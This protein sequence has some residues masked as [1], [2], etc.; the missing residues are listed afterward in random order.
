VLV[1]F[2][3][4]VLKD[5]G[6]RPTAFSDPPTQCGDPSPLVPTITP[7]VTGGD[8]PLRLTT[9][10]AMAHRH[11]SSCSSFYVLEAAFT[12]VLV[13]P[14]HM[15][16]VPG[17]KTDVQDCVW[18]AQLLEHGLLRGS[19]VP[20]APIRELRDLSRYRKVLIQD[21]TRE[22][23]RLHKLLEDA[24]IK[25]ASVATDVLGVS[26]R[27]M[28]EALVH[29]TTAPAVLA[30]LARGTL[31]KKLPALRQALAGRFRPHHAFL[32]S[33]LLAHL[34]YLDETIATLSQ[35][36]EEVIA[37]FAD[38]VARLDTIHGVAQRTAEVLI[39][40]LGVDMGQFPTDR[41]AVNESVIR[42][43]RS[44]PRRPRVMRGCS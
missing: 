34:D 15:A 24:G 39:A 28:L 12:C 36:I 16:Q 40:E 9:R 25:L 30:D 19:F 37:P 43:R 10:E 44:E 26:G 21:R 11:P 6:L 27:A 4:H 3:A 33:Q 23:N 18:I 5:V 35:R 42:R 1:S 14:V 7:H 22:A 13:N 32:V 31:R 29:G 2:A 20:P 17:R 38:E 8:A 41:G